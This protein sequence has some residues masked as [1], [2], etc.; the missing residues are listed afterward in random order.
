MGAPVGNVRLA[1]S[2]CGLTPK[3]EA[4]LLDM[5]NKLHA[6]NRRAYL[7][8]AERYKIDVAI[9][10]INARVNPP[11]TAHLLQQGNEIVEQL[12]PLMQEI[13]REAAALEDRCSP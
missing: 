8:G 13:D 7:G 9:Q 2:F 6:V 4:A 1:R 11:S 5:L 3:E 10:S 12:S